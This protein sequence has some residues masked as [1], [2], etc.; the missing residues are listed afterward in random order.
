MKNDSFLFTCQA[1]QKYIECMDKG[2]K[3]EAVYQ[4]AVKKANEELQ[5]FQE[6]GMPAV[7]EVN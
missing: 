3:L 1:S 5:V 6:K 7:L 2:K 4:A